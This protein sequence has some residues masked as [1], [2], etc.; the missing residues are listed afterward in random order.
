[1]KRIRTIVLTGGPCGGKSTVL[2]ALREEFGDRLVPV[3]EAATVLFEG[4]FPVPGRDIEWSEEWQEAFQPAVLA[5]QAALERSH[6]LLAADLDAVLVCDRGRLDGAAYTEGGVGAF[7]RIHGLDE[8]ET[9]GRYDLVI[10]LESLATSH[11]ERYGTE[12]NAA[13][14]ESLEQAQ[15]LEHA[16]REAWGNHPR[17]KVIGGERGMEGKIA[18]VIALVRELLG[19]DSEYSDKGQ[20]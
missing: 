14:Y 15:A 5:L 1:M 8:A 2:R 18:D 9:H 13:R 10:H 19:E 17:R 6:E 11:P 3:P 20:R 4:G 12:G 7:C 16:T